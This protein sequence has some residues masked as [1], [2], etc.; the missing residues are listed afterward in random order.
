VLNIGK[1]SKTIVMEIINPVNNYDTTLSFA[2]ERLALANPEP[3]QSGSYFTKISL[4]NNKPFFVQLPK[5]NTK[6]GLVDIKGVKYCDL[7]YERSTNEELVEWLE[8]LEYACQ[9]KLNEKKD[10]WFQTELSRD[11]IESM[12]SPIM[13]VY[14]SGKYILLRISVNP[15]KLNG[16]EKSIAYNEQQIN[17]DLDKLIATDSVV[18]LIVINGIRFSSRS[19]EIDI[20]L[21]QMMIFDKP[22]ETPCLIKYA[23]VPA[24]L[25]SAAN[26]PIAV[27]LAVPAAMANVPIA[28]A[29]VSTANQPIMKPPIMKTPIVMTMPIEPNLALEEVVLDYE[30]ISETISLKNPNEVY[31]EIY[32]AARIKA[33]QLRQ[34]AMEAYLAAKEIKT[35]YMLDD[36]SD[37]T[38]DSDNDEA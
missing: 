3:L 19:F 37:D 7:M 38:D 20:K 11:D 15:M 21:S 16:L 6:Q 27:P 9:D 24:T 33:K 1:I 4:E 18:P 22:T 12:M 26:V 8:K 35:K 23:N 36:D 17:V 28:M 32:R 10:L 25:V 5:C 30:N 2:F 14:Q 29:K 34:V 13:R 31:Y